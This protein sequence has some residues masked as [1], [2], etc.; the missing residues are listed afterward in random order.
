MA[1]LIFPSPTQ[2]K[3][4]S[5]PTDN[6]DAATKDY[7]DSKISSTSGAASGN[8]T[9]VQLNISG[10]IGSSNNFTFNPGSNTLYVGGTVSAVDLLLSGNVKSNLT[11]NANGT[12]SIGSAAQRYKDL[13][14]T[15]TA[16]V[17]NLIAT[18]A[19]IDAVTTAN[20][21]ATV[22]N[23]TTITTANLT[24]TDANIDSITVNNSFVINSTTQSTSTL[25]GTFVTQGGVG[26]QKDLYVGGTIHL[27][28][29]LGG[30]TSKGSINYN[31]G[32]SSIDFNFNNG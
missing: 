32:G 14:L 18:R 3:N 4:L 26:I 6:T 8:T 9:E 15:G 28:N 2:L 20:L 16:N 22:A 13:Y 10:A 30:T 7:V 27:A 1:A 29:G 17:A 12:F 19:N 21:T 24:A 5:G 11:P 31:D 23:I 25:T